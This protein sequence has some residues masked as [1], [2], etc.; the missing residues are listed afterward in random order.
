MPQENNEA[1]EL[2]HSE[3]VGFV[4]L[5]SRDQAAKVV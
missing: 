1:A 5:P 3:E 4:I 2:D